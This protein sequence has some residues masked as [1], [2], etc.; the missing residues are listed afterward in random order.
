M[1]GYQFIR[2]TELTQ[3]NARLQSKL[4][5]QRNELARLHQEVARLKREKKDLV[6]ELRAAKDRA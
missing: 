2:I 6:N 1:T 5:T 3:L 4:D